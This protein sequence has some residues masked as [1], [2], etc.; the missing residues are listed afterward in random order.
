MKAICWNWLTVADEI[1]SVMVSGIKHHFWDKLRTE[2]ASPDGCGLF[3]PLRS[4]ICRMG[5]G[6]MDGVIS[7]IGW[8]TKLS[9]PNAGDV[10]AD[11]VPIAETVAWS[12]SSAVWTVDTV[13]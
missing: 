4:G 6:V 13:P 8:K 9:A 2:I 5:G 3:W 10:N 11:C 7:E 1:R 12:P